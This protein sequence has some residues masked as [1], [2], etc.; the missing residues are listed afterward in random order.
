MSISQGIWLNPLRLSSQGFFRPLFQ[1]NY[2]S[3]AAGS[4]SS[5]TRLGII[6][7]RWREEQLVLPL[8]ESE[9]LGVLGYLVD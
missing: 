1:F 7:R 4:T 8:S 6:D 2:E 3:I 5:V 9:C